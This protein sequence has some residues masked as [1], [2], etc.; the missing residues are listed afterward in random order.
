MSQLK[1]ER[2]KLYFLKNKKLNI[3][4]KNKKTENTDLRK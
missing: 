1:N 2:L 3:L 4:I